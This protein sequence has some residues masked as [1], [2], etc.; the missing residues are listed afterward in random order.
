MVGWIMVGWIMV[1]G[2]LSTFQCNA[3]KI[4]NIAG[5]NCIDRVSYFHGVDRKGNS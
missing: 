2:F 3:P 5:K 1:S 4:W